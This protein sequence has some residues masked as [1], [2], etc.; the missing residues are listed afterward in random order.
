[1][2]ISIDKLPAVPRLKYEEVRQH[3]HSGDLLFCSGNSLFSRLIKGIT[4]SIW[5][6]VGFIIR[7]DEIERLIVLE[8]VESIGVR[9]VALS[10]YI[11]D[12]D[13]HGKPYDGNILIARHEDFEESMV[14]HISKHAIDLLGR[15]YDTSEIMKIG[16]RIT[17]SKFI[18]NDKCE[19]PVRDNE[20]ICSEYVYECYQS[21]G[22]NIQH[23]RGG[24]ISP[25]D[26]A[27]DEKINPICL[28]NV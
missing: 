19:L 1:M 11:K 10:H 25:A 20:Y 5:S 15:Q 7:W 18:D 8:S 23:N 17:V 9:S 13:G 4:G 12:Y 6:H 2:T 21:V 14:N 3:I 28:I 16:S 27:M 22:I 24:F 26:F